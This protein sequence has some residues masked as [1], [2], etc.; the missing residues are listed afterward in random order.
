MK[1][2]LAAFLAVAVC[3]TSVSAQDKSTRKLTFERDNGIWIAN[4][5]GS[6][7]KKLAT[8]QSPDL[9]PDGT[10]LVYSSSSGLGKD[11]Q[12]HI[13]I[14]DLTTNQTAILKDIPNDDCVEPSWSHDGKQLLFKFY[15]TDAWHIGVD[16]ADGTGFRDV[17]AS[18]P[19]HNDYWSMAWAADGKSFYTQD[20]VNL[21]QLDLNAKVIKQ[22]AIDKLVPHGG[23]SGGI[24]LDASPD[25][26]SLL[27]DVEMDEKER[28]DWDG[29]PPSIWLLDLAT[30][31][32][33]RLTPPS[34][35]AWDSHWLQAPDSIL[36]VSANPGEDAEWVYR[37]S[38]KGQGKD[39]QLLIKNGINPGSSR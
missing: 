25:G 1:T 27:M 6:S 30:E 28:K 15:V 22:W 21:Y 32:A 18:D 4:I 24:R 9:S 31:K 13:A 39:K 3:S 33:T 38:T 14:I 8:G 5:D 34:L 20:M 2:I 26:K 29:P 37:M 19:K 11:M 23:M 36:F 7:E 16:N 17:Q 12:H 35:Y 10:K